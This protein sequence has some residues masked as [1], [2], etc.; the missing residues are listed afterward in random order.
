MKIKPKPK[1]KPFVVFRDTGRSQW[2]LDQFETLAKAEEYAQIHSTEAEH[3]CVVYESIGGN[4]QRRST[5][6]DHEKS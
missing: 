6:R 2:E 4:L 5:W 1:E 3:T